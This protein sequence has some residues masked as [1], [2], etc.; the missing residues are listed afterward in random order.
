M[1]NAEE[2]QVADVTTVRICPYLNKPFQTLS[3]AGLIV[4]RGQL[5]APVGYKLGIFIVV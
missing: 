2:G 5:F 4:K 1:A 3:D